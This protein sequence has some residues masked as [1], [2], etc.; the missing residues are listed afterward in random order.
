[1][2]SR[3]WQIDAL[4]KIAYFTYV[5]NMTT[6]D[7]Q[8]KARDKCFPYNSGCCTFAKPKSKYP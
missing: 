5:S 3:Y 4:T 2:E 1:M 6:L 7:V 8:E